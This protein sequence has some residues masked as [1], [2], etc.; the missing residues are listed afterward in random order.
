MYLCVRGEGGRGGKPVSALGAQERLEEVVEARLVVGQVHLL[1]ELLA[2]LVA[3]VR[4]W[5]ALVALGLIKKGGN[6]E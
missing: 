1:D 4:G 2:A 3:L 6:R 5:A